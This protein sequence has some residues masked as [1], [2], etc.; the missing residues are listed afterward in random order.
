[1]AFDSPGELRTLLADRQLGGV[2]V[3]ESSDRPLAQSLAEMSRGV[4]LWK[5]FVLAALAFLLAEILL[6]R[7]LG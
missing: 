7:F 6:L 5:W 1:M 3:L 4:Q 2:Q